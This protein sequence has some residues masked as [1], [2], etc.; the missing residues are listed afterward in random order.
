MFKSGV[1]GDEIFKVTTYAP[2][3]LGKYSPHGPGAVSAKILIKSLQIYT[4][5]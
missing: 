1:C 2:E 4:Y 3:P 5:F